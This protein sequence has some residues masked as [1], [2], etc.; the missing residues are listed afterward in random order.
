M[1]RPVASEKAVLWGGLGSEAHK[2]DARNLRFESTV[3][4]SSELNSGWLAT[5]RLD[6]QPTGPRRADKGLH[7]EIGFAGYYWENDGSRNTLTEGG[8]AVDPERPDLDTASG[9]ELSGALDTAGFTLDFQRNVIRGQTVDRDFTGGVYLAG[10]TRGAASTIQSGYWIHR[11]VQLAAGATR[12]DTRSY[13]EPWKERILGINFDLQ[14][15]YHSK[16]QIT[17]RWIDNRFGVPG[18]DYFEVRLQ[19]QHIW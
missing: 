16:L 13:L 2:Q 15:K 12:F 17:G 11:L 10:E 8:V 3:G 7:F 4:A 1:R 14:D 5:G 19:T 18:Q 9:L 6:L